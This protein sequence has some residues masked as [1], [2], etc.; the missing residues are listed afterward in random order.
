MNILFASGVLLPQSLPGFD[1]FGGF[2][3][4]YAN[5]DIKPF[6]PSVPPAGLISGR[7]GA[8]AEQIDIALARGPFDQNQRIHI[9]AHSM[10]GLDSRFLISNDVGG[11]RSRIA[12]LTTISTPH[13]GSP[14]ADLLLG[15]PRPSIGDP[16]WLQFQLIEHALETIGIDIGGFAQLTTEA[17]ARFGSQVPDVHGFPYFS[18]A[19][20]G[21]GGAHP[22][23]LPFLP[24]HAYIAAVGQTP[25]EKLNDGMV[26][27]SSANFG[28]FLDQWAADHFEEVGHSLDPIPLSPQFN[29]LSQVDA[30][31]QRLRML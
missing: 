30:I 1:Y 13:R 28:V 12:S 29:A 4:H 26:S 6:F 23:T 19:G 31:I 5:T 18:V 25:A 17:T 11:L 21:H 24:T 3:E 16:R 8:L 10:G 7:A 27:L 14:V 22:T 2:R 20:I 9:I 15:S